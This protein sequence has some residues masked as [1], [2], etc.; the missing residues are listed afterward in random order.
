M[1]IVDITYDDMYDIPVFFNKKENAV[2][3]AI[4]AYE[5]IIYNEYNSIEEFNDD[6]GVDYEEEIL[7]EIKKANYFDDWL[8]IEEIKPADALE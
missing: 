4:K 8:T 7:P 2:K 6:C 5:K 1:Y 3:Y